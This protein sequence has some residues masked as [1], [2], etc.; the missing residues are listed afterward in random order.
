MRQDVVWD[1]RRG[2]GQRFNWTSSEERGAKLVKLTEVCVGG[3]TTAAWVEEVVM[4]FAFFVKYVTKSSA[5][6]DGGRGEGE[7]R[8][9]TK[10]GRRKWLIHHVHE[11]QHVRCL[12]GLN[13]LLD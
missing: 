6:S 13:T 11:P 4:S 10:Q 8:R 12:Q 9:K 1:G 3:G 5:V 2:S 7:W